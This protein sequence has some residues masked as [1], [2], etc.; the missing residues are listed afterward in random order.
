MTI[1]E[2]IIERIEE[3]ADSWADRIHG[4]PN[5]TPEDEDD[6]LRVS[7]MNI[8]INIIQGIDLLELDADIEHDEE[9]C[10]PEEEIQYAGD[11]YGYDDVN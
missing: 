9:T 11:I 8:A 7:G 1:R 3:V 5:R 4:N 6:L 2:L 10:P